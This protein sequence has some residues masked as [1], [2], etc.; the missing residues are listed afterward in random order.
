MSCD[1]F[2]APLMA[3]SEETHPWEVRREGGGEEVRRKE[4]GREEGGRR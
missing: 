4:G 2:S 1:V 3:V